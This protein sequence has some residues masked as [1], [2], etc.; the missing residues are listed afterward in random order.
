MLTA[1]SLRRTRSWRPKNSV[2]RLNSAVRMYVLLINLLFLNRQDQWLS[3]SGIF[4][5]HIPWL[6]IPNAVPLRC[7]R[8]TDLF[9]L[10][11]RLLLFNYLCPLS[12]P[13][14]V[15]S[16]RPSVASRLPQVDSWQPAARMKTFD[17]WKLTGVLIP[18]W[19]TYCTQPTT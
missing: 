13:L 2:T 17:Y 3:F 4:L 7:H 19:M 6:C 16:Q 1:G 8:K 9:K 15:N 11:S 10:L 18:Q 14:T 5:G 12:F